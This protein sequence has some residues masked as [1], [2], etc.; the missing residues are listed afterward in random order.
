M[1]LET[2]EVD[3]T[4]IRDP[5]RPVAVTIG[6]VLILLG[7]A[8]L[9]G[10]LDFDYLDDG[11][12][13]GVFGVPFWLGVTAIVAGILGVVLAS[14]PGGATTFDKLAAVIVLPAVLFLAV[15]DWALATDGLAVLALGLV[16]L[17]LAVVFAAIGTV[18]LLGHPLAFVLPVVAVL[19]ILDWGLSITALV[20]AESANLPTLALLVVLALV[21]VVIGFEGGRRLTGRPEP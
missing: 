6:V 1:V 4:G 8:G 17:L 13:L 10:V 11:L 16:A 21:M 19:A 12:V 2:P 20:P 18:L 9:T 7:I 15:T 5:Q 14:Y 3:L